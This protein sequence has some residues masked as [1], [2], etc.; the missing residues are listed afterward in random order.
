MAHGLPVVAS[1]LPV[2]E[3][4]LEGHD[5][6]I[7]FERENAEALAEAMERMIAGNHWLTLKEKAKRY[8]ALF[9]IENKVKEWESLLAPKGELP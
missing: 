7:L 4:L 1:R 3:E 5:E 2:T 6:A 9:T 8:A